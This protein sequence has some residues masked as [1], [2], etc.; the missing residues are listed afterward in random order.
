MTQLRRSQV[1][2][3][4]FV[5]LA[6][7]MFLWWVAGAGMFASVQG[8]SYDVDIVV[9]RAGSLGPGGRVR[10]SGVDV[11]RVTS[12]KQVASGAV[13][14]LNL[15]DEHAPLPAD[16]RFTVRLHTLVGESYVEL[17]P[18][19]SRETVP[20]GGMLAAGLALDYVD[21]DEILNVFR[22]PAQAEARTAL[23]SLGAGLDG[24]GRDLNRTLDHTGGFIEDVAPLARVLDDERGHVVQLIDDVGAVMRAVGGRGDSLH[25]LATDARATFTALA[26][27]D[28]ALR[29]VLRELPET[30]VQARTTSST[31]RAVS[32]STTPVLTD[33]GQAL[34][35][36][37][38]VVRG[39]QPTADH[40][41]D[42]VRE[43]GRAAPPLRTTLRA[44]E[45]VSPPAVAALPAARRLLCQV[46]P[47]VEYLAPYAKDVGEWIAGLGSVTNYY[48]AT[49]HAARLLSTMV[50]ARAGF[51]LQDEETVQ[52]AK[53]LFDSGL[54]TPVT[55]AGYEPFPL[56]GRIND[57]STGGEAAGPSE[58]TREYQRVEA[59]C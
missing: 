20:D 37:K 7:G 42:L 39:L 4:F 44:L 8:R 22:G 51:T 11:G 1:L 17:V 10:V 58:V 57:G 55:N 33:L 56:L 28:Q 54:V 47:L 36:A 38:P 52:A 46:N 5:V 48:D 16:T 21:A 31:L 18:G 35:G 41:R 45:E 24:R 29:A 32:R 49:G 50:P 9:P 6:T 40:G 25:S 19:R 12:I 53:L 27:R 23:R 3:G 13:I 34:I 14:G 43:L 59:E 2:V 26:E 15:E 30:L